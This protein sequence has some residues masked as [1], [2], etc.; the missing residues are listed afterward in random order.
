EHPSVPTWNYMVVHAYGTPRLVEDEDRVRADLRALV[1]LHE[2]G[3]DVPW[4]MDLPEEYVARMVR[5]IVAFEL[6]ISRLEGKFKLSQNRPT[7]DRERVAAALAESADPLARDVQ[8]MLKAD[9]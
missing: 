9:H 2:Q 1:G 5:G 4:T 3:R 6:P 8:A 7:R